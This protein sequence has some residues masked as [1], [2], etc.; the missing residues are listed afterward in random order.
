MLFDTEGTAP[1]INHG[2]TAVSKTEKGNYVMDVK[3]ANRF[4]TL[5]FGGADT[6]AKLEILEIKIKMSA[7]SLP[8][9]YGFI[10]NYRRTAP[11]KWD[12]YVF[13][14]STDK[15]FCIMSTKGNQRT[16]ICEWE[17]HFD[18]YSTGYNIVRI[19]KR[20][21]NM[22]RFYI[23]NELVFHQNLG[24]LTLQFGGLYTDPHAILYVDYVKMGVFKKE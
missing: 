24:P 18:V 13:L 1:S 9:V 12:D 17:P 20:A 11:N 22:Y 7:D 10:W 2:D 3:H 19:E 5:H 21:G 15:Q 4:W 8:G 14:L 16:L 6:L 23:N